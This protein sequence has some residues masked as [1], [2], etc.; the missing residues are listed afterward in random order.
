[1]DKKDSQRNSS[2]GGRWAPTANLSQ[3]S[4]ALEH[5]LNRSANLPGIVAY[6]GPSGVGKSM[7]AS[8][9]A[10]KFEGVYVECRSFFTK[11]AFVFA[12]LKEMGIRPA[13]TL[14]E[15]MDQAAEQLD[16]SQ[17][18]LI[19]DEMDHMV[20]RNAI[21]IVR[22]LYEM[23]RATI[24]LIGEEHF[25]SKL[26]RQSERFHNRVLT[27]LPA[28]PASLADCRQLAKFYA[29]EHGIDDGMLK[30]ILKAS[31]GTARRIC[32]NIELVRQHCVKQGLKEIDAEEW[33]KRPLY[34]GDAPRRP[35]GPDDEPPRRP[36]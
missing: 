32:V 14:A 9:C 15:M 18:P 28:Q 29:P 25:P 12:V 8:Y 7:A 31:G 10:N 20:D 4:A 21:E 23:S 24:L 35:S 17:R 26:L 22:D 6:C 5:A 36:A 30:L 33:G 3:A 2:I 16:L 13:R 27:W 34:T 11:K 1:M 19:I